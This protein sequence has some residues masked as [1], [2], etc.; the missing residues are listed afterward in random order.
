MKRYLLLPIDLVIGGYFIKETQP[1][2]PCSNMM[3]FDES[4]SS[5][6]DILK[7]FN[8][9][10]SVLYLKVMIDLLGK[11]AVKKLAEALR[12][13]CVFIFVFVYLLTH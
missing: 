3:F 11:V 5:T 2:K 13:F 7:P 8:S 10:S 4:F 9:T 1:S 6:A 12:S